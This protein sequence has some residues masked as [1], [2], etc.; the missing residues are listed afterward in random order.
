MRV[1]VATLGCKVNQ[2]DSASIETYLRSAG[3]TMVAFAPGADVY[4][5]NTCTV[6]DRGDAESRQLARRARRFGPAAR[7]ILTGCFAQID[8][9]G[10]AIPEVDH[11]IGL[12]RLPDLVRAVRGELEARSDRILVD[13]L[14]TTR[15]V[16]TLGAE[17]FTGQTRAFLK[18]QEGCD[19]FCSFCIVPFARGGGRSVPP[20]QVLEQLR[21]LAERGFQEV[22]LTG[23]H[24]GGYGADLDPKI[25]FPDLLHRVVEQA[26]VPRIRISSIDP[27]EVT[28]RLL[29]LLRDATVLCPHLHVPIQAGH[30]EVLRRMR[31]KYTTAFVRELCGLIRQQLP[32][33]A[34]GTDVIAGFPG[35]TE[36]QFE[37]GMRF[38]AALP[39][40]YFHVF[41]Y[42]RRAGTTAAKLPGHLPPH[43]IRQRARRL[44]ALGQR[45][46]VEF[47]RGFIGRE[48]QVLAEQ[49]PARSGGWLAGYTR[50][51]Q[52]VE[53]LGPA[54]LTNREVALRIVSC[55]GERLLGELEAGRCDG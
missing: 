37:E 42:S 22:V 48:M 51:Y 31:R 3:C 16:K 19:L 53:F 20:V 38:L 7:V 8:P 13:D 14:R 34:I 28:P 30:D 23:V 40:T 46:R 27:P 47:A 54:Q 36:A 25:D 41:P 17:S 49:T 12:N 52:R 26:P 15:K 29:Y 43:V 1:A 9:H 55:R 45:K 10:A 2:Y 6:T 21:M 18:I 39:L 4:I 24:L 32:D 44:R 5:V 11:V 35:E 33:A 50:S